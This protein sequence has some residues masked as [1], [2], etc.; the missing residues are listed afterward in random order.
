MLHSHDCLVSWSGVMVEG[1]Q[2]W[3]DWHTWSSQ[4]LGVG[5]DAVDDAVLGGILAE[6]P[7]TM[8][9]MY[10]SMNAYVHT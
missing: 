5:H 4:S 10:T 3:S 2:K 8:I 7:A 6:L 9:H 1:K